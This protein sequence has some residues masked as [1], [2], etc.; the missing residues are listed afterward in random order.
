MLAIEEFKS[1]H[2]RDIVVITGS[3]VLWSAIMYV[4]EGI[5]SLSGAYYVAL[6][7]LVLFLSFLVLS[8]QKTGV[9]SLFYALCAVLTYGTRELGIAY[10]D[11]F[12]ILLGAALVFELV[13]LTLKLR[14]KNIPL[15]IL[16]GAVL[17]TGMLPL[18]TGTLIS[19]EASLQ[20]I[21]S[22]LN[23]AIIG[24]LV[25]VIGAVLAFLIWYHF[26][27]TKWLVKLSMP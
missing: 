23:L 6:F 15:D 26:K 16:A 21:E 24:L 9:A 20:Q 18:I 17:S 2:L 13:F 8:L 25:G 7:T 19:P 14:V 5:L 3:A 4:L 27:T 22:L 11:K 1:F 12:I 10:S